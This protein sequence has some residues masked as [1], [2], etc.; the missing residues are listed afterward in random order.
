MRQRLPE[1]RLQGFYAPYHISQARSQAFLAIF[2]LK[3]ICGI[4]YRLPIRYKDVYVIGINM[5]FF[6]AARNAFLL[7]SI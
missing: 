1:V 4:Q 2:T 3:F 6:I 5:Y 7:H